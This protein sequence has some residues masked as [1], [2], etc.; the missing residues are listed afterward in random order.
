MKK[1]IYNNINIAF[2][3]YTT[4]W[5]SL[6]KTKIPNDAVLAEME[7]IYDFVHNY[8]VDWTKD[9]MGTVLVR[10]EKDI[11]TNYPYLGDKA[12]SILKNH[13]TYEWK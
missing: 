9:V 13:F 4:S 12:I 2:D 3:K 8:Y 1:D 6:D 5:G 7:K 11:R 10:L